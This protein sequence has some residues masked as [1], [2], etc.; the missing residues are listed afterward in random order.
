MTY[1]PLENPARTGARLC[2][3]PVP[4][5]TPALRKPRLPA[6]H[7]TAAGARKFPPLPDPDA[8]YLRCAA[9]S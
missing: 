9:D 2:L 4:G 1:L 8:I 6:A 5:F 7:A 3:R